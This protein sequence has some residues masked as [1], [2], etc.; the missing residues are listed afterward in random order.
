MRTIAAETGLAVTTVSRALAE[1]PHIKAATRALV[2]AA[3]DRQGYVPDRAA[4]RLRT[5]RTRVVQL[6]LNLDHEFLGVTHELIG[7]LS[8]ALAGTGYSVTI[9]PD[10][11]GEDRLARV[12]RIV[13]TRLG[14]G[15]IFN[16]TEPFDPRVRYLLEQGFPFVSHGR[17]EF[18]TPHPWVDFDNE[19]FARIAVERLIAKG[20][21]RLLM[22][23]PPANFSFAQHLRW[24][25][26]AAAKGAGIICEIPEAITLDTSER[27]T[28]AW[29]RHRLSQPDRPDG[30][31]GVGEVAAMA[32][33]AAISDCGLTPGDQ[34]D[35]VAK[36]ASAIFDLMR[37]RIDTMVEDLRLAGRTMGETLLRTMAG[38][39]V[40]QLQVLHQ[41]LIEF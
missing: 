33:L 19:A 7:G 40:S 9:F 11:I 23:L 34:I 14:D 30:I 32:A 12:R 39:D 4:Q 28:I 35:V 3:A 37:P 38:E 29:L 16:R 1:D 27:E 18:T 24:G 41:P 36:R 6:L 2:R 15:V 21:K 26:V 20:R 25:A 5:G 13:E 17:T 8:E 10:L 31:I 22:I